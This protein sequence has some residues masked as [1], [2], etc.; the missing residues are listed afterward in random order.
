MKFIYEKIFLLNSVENEAVIDYLKTLE[1]YPLPCTTC[2]A[3]ERGK[4]NGYN[5]WTYSLEEKES[6]NVISD[7]FKATKKDREKFINLQDEE[8][9]QIIENRYEYNRIK[10]N[11]DTSTD[12]VHLLIKNKYN[13]EKLCKI[14]VDFKI[15]EVENMW[16]IDEQEET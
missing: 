9:K 2:E 13:K 7:W 4:C 3:K 16:K 8:L 6:C 14:T 5:L 12:P 11:L 1:L 15:G 10:E